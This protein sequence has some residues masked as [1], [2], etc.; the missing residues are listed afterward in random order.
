[1]DHRGRVIV[2]DVISGSQL[3]QS[4]EKQYPEQKKH[5]D[6]AL[7]KILIKDGQIMDG[8]F[9]AIK[10]EWDLLGAKLATLSDEEQGKFFKGFAFELSKFE[11]AYKRQLQ[12]FAIRDK[13]NKKEIE[14]LKESL[15][16]LWYESELK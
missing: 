10:I 6:N 1:M 7:A 4:I 12:V 8:T 15:S 9:D 5:C 11:S 16:C 3:T 13:L 14:I 2:V